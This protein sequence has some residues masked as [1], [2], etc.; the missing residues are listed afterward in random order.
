MQVALDVTMY[1]GDTRL[2]D[3]VITRAGVV[4]D[5]TNATVWFT[6]KRSLTDADVD[7]V[8]Q[9]YSPSNGVQITGA[10]YGEVRVTIPPSATDALTKSEAL[11]WDLQVKEANGNISTTASG[12][13]LVKLDVTRT[14]T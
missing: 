3:F 8:F 4:V 10:T 14:T 6:A 2:L 5:L 7:A 9:L 12:T 1:R 13:L 11:Y